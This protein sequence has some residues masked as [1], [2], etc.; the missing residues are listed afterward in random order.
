[1]AAPE[2]GAMG[3]SSLKRLAAAR[4]L[5][6][7]EIDGCL[8]QPQPK[9]ALIELLTSLSADGDSGTGTDNGGGADDG[10]AAAEEGAADLSAGRALL[11]CVARTTRLE[12]KLHAHNVSIS[13]LLRT[14]EQSEEGAEGSAQDR[15]ERAEGRE[16]ILANMLRSAEARG[17]DGDAATPR[18][19]EP[20]P[21]PEPQPEPE[22][23]PVPPPIP[24][25]SPGSFAS[26][27]SAP[28]EGANSVDQ[29]EHLSDGYE[30]VPDDDEEEEPL[31]PWLAA[32]SVEHAAG[33]AEAMA[34]IPGMAM[35]AS[36]AMKRGDLD[37][38]VEQYSAALG[39]IPSGGA[40]PGSDL[41]SRAA[42]LYNSRAAV[43]FELG[44][45]RE[46]LRDSDESVLADADAFANDRQPQLRAALCCLRLGELRE[47]RRRFE[48]LDDP[49]LPF[50][51]HLR[52]AEEAE[53][54]ARG[55][56]RAESR[57]A[58][59]WRRVAE[60]MASVCEH[61]CPRWIEGWVLRTAVLCAAGE[62]EA[63]AGSAQAGMR[64]F[65]EQPD[66]LVLLGRCMLRLHAP[67]SQ[68]QQQGRGQQHGQE[69]GD[70]KRYWERALRLDPDSHGAA[71][72][73]KAFRRVAAQSSG[74]GSSSMALEEAVGC[75]TTQLACSN[76]A[77]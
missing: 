77:C 46:A 39:C 58:A 69:Q 6:E 43:L 70:A 75:Y 25:W 65:G 28:D 47:S 42:A 30:E 64:R 31:P 10:S 4:G 50:W 17:P 14:W 67:G 18:M 32:G 76:T 49:E 8:E 55:A 15:L 27:Y 74:G 60:Q 73:L 3:W 40:E 52:S 5:S 54:E 45:F 68:Q 26:D 23:E 13:F 57:P 11:Q 22:L 37:S 1:M 51:K 62:W 63:G 29:A 38:A 61:T 59:E 72:Y 16:R 21:E 33:V 2:L 66:L 53:A 24:P 9:H 20:E 44:R 41:C 19:P 71:G 56:R 36:A 34:K 7:T 35:A 12:Q 48:Q